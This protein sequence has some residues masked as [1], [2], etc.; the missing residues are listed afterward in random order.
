M[1]FLLA[2]SVTMLQTSLHNPNNSLPQM[3]L[4]RWLAS[5]KG[6]NNGGDFPEFFFF[7]VK[8]LTL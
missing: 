1:A 5:N 4:S 7:C 6:L 2:F 3:T 8:N